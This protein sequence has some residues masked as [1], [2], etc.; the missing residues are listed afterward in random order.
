[1]RNTKNF[2]KPVVLDFSFKPIKVEYLGALDIDNM[3]LRPE[4]H[5][6]FRLRNEKLKKLNNVISSKLQVDA[7][8]KSMGS[9]RRKSDKEDIVSIKDKQT[10]AKRQLTLNAFM[11]KRERENTVIKSDKI[12]KV[13]EQDSNHKER[14]KREM[15]KKLLDRQS[16]EKMSVVEL[17]NQSQYKE[18]MKYSKLN[19]T[20]E[21]WRRI[22]L[23][24]DHDINIGQ[25]KKEIIHKRDTLFQEK[26][27]PILNLKDKFIRKSIIGMNE[28]VDIAKEQKFKGFIG[29]PGISLKI[30]LPKKKLILKKKKKDQEI[31][32]D[33]SEEDEEDSHITYESGEEFSQSKEEQSPTK[34]QPVK[35]QNINL[36]EKL[37]QN[38]LFEFNLP[39]QG[40]QEGLFRTIVNE[41]DHN[42]ITK[43]EYYKDIKDHYK[44][45][46]E[47]VIYQ[48]KRSTVYKSG[49]GFG[50]AIN[51]L[52]FS[53]NLQNSGS[54]TE[55]KDYVRESQ[56]SN[57]G[58]CTRQSNQN[59]TREFHKRNID[60]NGIYQDKGQNWGG[61]K[62][63]MM[64]TMGDMSEPVKANEKEEQKNI[65]AEKLLIK[66]DTDKFVEDN[67]QPRY[68]LGNVAATKNTQQLNRKANSHR[69][70][71]SRSQSEA[72][73]SG[74]NPNTDDHQLINVINTPNIKKANLAQSSKSID[75]TKKSHL[76]ETPK[77]NNAKLPLTDSRRGSQILSKIRE[78]IPGKRSISVD[79][80]KLSR[81]GARYS[82]VS[83]FSQVDFKQRPHN[84][85]DYINN[86]FKPKMTVPTK[87]DVKK[88]I[89]QI[90]N[91]SSLM[92]NFINNLGETINQSNQNDVKHHIH[93]WVNANEANV[94]FVKNKTIDMKR[95]DKIKRK[96]QEMPP[97]FRPLKQIYESND[98]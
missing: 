2:E 46:K 35:V 85:K 79:N 89:E 11:K 49:S 9:L 15:F 66:R 33:T 91:V 27:G 30:Q 84:D 53:E 6:R 87:V 71:V 7:F 76:S 59:T 25:L 77:M 5:E 37:S 41:A 95:F 73:H 32:T 63:S 55:R 81:F 34:K 21:I 28:L 80:R 23:N 51:K 93:E 18:A 26:H 69:I 94:D 39:E 42:P 14:S 58:N 3:D 98:F 74:I 57:N 43:I 96:V 92:T 24:D 90:D 52:R 19:N 31:H 17:W 97:S 47:S 40:N 67:G 50:L 20:A 70:I 13:P 78:R 68:Y 45:K 60:T 82:H 1:M 72:F 86:D 4:V 10:L 22:A 64:K 44:H 36:P 65:H 29:K 88:N 54:A 83:N 61:M 16:S 75:T 12:H 48:P 56:T 62:N 38:P 8:S